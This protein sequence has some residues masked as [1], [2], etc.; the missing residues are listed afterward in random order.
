MEA[1]S[2]ATCSFNS[3]YKQQQQQQG[4]SPQTSL[5]V[6]PVEHA[7]GFAIMMEKSRFGSKLPHPAT[8]LTH[9]QLTT[10][11]GLIWSSH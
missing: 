8:S 11:T 7:S 2:H 1:A 10:T 6:H 3:S 5:S 4:V 9:V